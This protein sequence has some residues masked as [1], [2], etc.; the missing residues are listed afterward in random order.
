MPKVMFRPNPTPPPFV[1]PTPPEPTNIV[2]LSKY[3]FEKGEPVL[4]YFKNVEVPPAEANTFD[5]YSNSEQSWYTVWEFYPSLPDESNPFETNFEY[6]S[7][8]IGGYQISSFVQGVVI[9]TIPLVV[10]TA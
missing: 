10:Q 3:P 7:A 5:I 9:K 6:D 2:V 4:V 1:P 8:D